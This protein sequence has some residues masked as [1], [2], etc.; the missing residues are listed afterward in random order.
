MKR[1]RFNPEDAARSCLASRFFALLLAA[2]ILLAAKDGQAQLIEPN[3]FV[4][5]PPGSNAIQGYYD[6]G[7]LTEFSVANGPTF[8]DHTGLQVNL[9]AVRYLHYFAVGGH[10]AA[11]QVYQIFGSE[12]GGQI[13]GQSIGSASG[14]MD[15]ALNAAFWPYADRAHSRYLVVVGWFYPPTG[16]YDPHSFLNLGD[17]RWKGD[18]QLGWHGAIATKVSYDLSF[19]TTF[20]GDNDNAFP[21][22]LTLTQTPTYELQGWVNWRWNPRFQTSLGYLGTFGGEQSV[23]GVLN[24]Q[25][26]EEQRLRAAV[27]YLITPRLQVLLEIN[28]DVQAVGGFKQEFGLLARVTAVF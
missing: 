3:D 26:T 21:G 4:P 27:S 9:G 2:M 22:G 16:T 14:A 12:S 8:T 28:H 25:K 24:G 17:N 6:Y 15:V 5:L 19:D 11:V 10:P 23:N 1:L 7:N 13:G 20:Y 18:V